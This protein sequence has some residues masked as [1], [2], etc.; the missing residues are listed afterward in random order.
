MTEIYCVK[1]KIKSP[2]NNPTQVIL[3]NGANALSGTC[4]ACGTK[5]F[6]FL[7]RNSGSGFYLGKG[8]EKKKTSKAKLII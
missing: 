7:P 5:K 3:K 6:K 8:R 2:T 4:S 1:C